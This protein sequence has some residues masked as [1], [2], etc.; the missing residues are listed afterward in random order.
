MQLEFRTKTNPTKGQL[1]TVKAK[2]CIT[3]PQF[4]P[5]PL[6]MKSHHSK[7]HYRTRKE[8]HED[9]FHVSRHNL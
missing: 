5:K 8:P 3:G 2:A 4:R 1:H 6:Q 7:C 9:H